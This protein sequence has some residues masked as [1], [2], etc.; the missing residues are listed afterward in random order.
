MIEWTNVEDRLPKSLPIW[1]HDNDY[2]V[3]I[4]S[5][6]NIHG[7]GRWYISDDMHDPTSLYHVTHWMPIRWPDPP[8]GD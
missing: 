6:S 5:Y 7:I 8:T 1:I 2:G 4:G 3:V